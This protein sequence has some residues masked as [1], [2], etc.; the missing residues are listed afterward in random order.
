MWL[1][2][3]VQADV[4]AGWVAVGGVPWCALSA[5]PL[6]QSH[7]RSWHR[8]DLQDSC[9]L[10]AQSWQSHSYPPRHVAQ[11]HS[12][13]T[14]WRVSELL[15]IPGLLLALCSP[16]YFLVLHLQMPGFSSSDS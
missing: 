13:L 4:Q 7:P 9:K 5:F 1:S 12:L 8:R 14:K 2:F 11:I 15:V 16:M 10:K 6:Q 3:S